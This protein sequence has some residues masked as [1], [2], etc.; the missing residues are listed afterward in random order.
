MDS[1]DYRSP[2]G[3]IFDIGGLF[4]PFGTIVPAGCKTMPVGPEHSMAFCLRLASIG[5]VTVLQCECNSL[6]VKPVIV[7]ELSIAGEPTSTF[8]VLGPA[9]DWIY[10]HSEIDEIGLLFTYQALPL[11]LTDKERAEMDEAYR[12]YVGHEMS[13][14]RST[15]DAARFDMWRRLAG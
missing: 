8:V 7:D 15:S 14:P 4:A 9:G 6:T 12:S 13:S 1:L 2:G 3:I 11:A 5:G 10:I